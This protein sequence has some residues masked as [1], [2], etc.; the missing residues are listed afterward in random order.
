MTPE[1]IEELRS[2]CNAATPG[3][4]VQQGSNVI[5]PETGEDVAYYCA[6]R[7]AEFIAAARTALPEALAE[8]ERLRA[9]MQALIEGEQYRIFTQ[10]EFYCVHGISCCEECSNCFDDYL[11]NV[12]Y[13][14]V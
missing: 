4:W 11:Q 14:K 6:M 8:I 1:R 10:D 5:A 3:P 7:D 2:L 9:A 12:L 13:G